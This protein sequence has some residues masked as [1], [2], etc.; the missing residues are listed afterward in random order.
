MVVVFI[1]VVL[2]IMVIIVVAPYLGYLYDYS[3]WVPQ[4]ERLPYLFLC[5]SSTSLDLVL[6]RLC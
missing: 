6:M 2:V 5:F 3:D 4:T 1:D